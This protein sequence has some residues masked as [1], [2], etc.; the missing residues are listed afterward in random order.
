MNRFSTAVVILLLAAC[1]GTERT[2]RTFPLS[3]AADTASLTTDSGWAVTLTSAR[4]SLTSARFFT[5]KVL[6]GKRLD[7]LS[8]LIPTAYAHPGHYQQGEAVGELLVAKDFDLLAG[9]TEWGTANAVTGEY[10]SVQLGVASMRLTG[11]ATKGAASVQF[12]TGDFAPPAPLEGLRFER[13]MDTKPGSVLLTVNLAGVLSRIDFAQI[14][15]SSSPLDQTSPAFNGFAR[16][17]E[18]TSVYAV[19]WRPQ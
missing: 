17:V 11:T 1:G 19:T 4:A 7:P 10:G 6:I 12:D 14:G 3:V 13:V 5:G 15:A 9:E 18:D 8:W 16:G 2:R